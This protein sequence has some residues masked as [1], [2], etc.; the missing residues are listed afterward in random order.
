MTQQQYER[1]QVVSWHSAKAY[2]FVA[3]DPDD[4][5]GDLFVHLSAVSDGQP[6]RVGQPVWFLRG[7]GRDGRPAAIYVEAQEAGVTHE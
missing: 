2:G 3:A 4:G 5:G 6:L 1:G 7:A